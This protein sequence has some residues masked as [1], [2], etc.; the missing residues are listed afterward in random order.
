MIVHCLLL[1]DPRRFPDTLA[2]LALGVVLLVLLAIWGEAISNGIR[3]EGSTVRAAVSGSAALLAVTASLVAA[4]LFGWDVGS[5]AVAW[6]FA[7][8]MVGVASVVGG[9][10]WIVVAMIRGGGAARAGR[11]TWASLSVAVM[12]LLGIVFLA[13]HPPPVPD[14]I[15]DA[16]ALDA[17][18]EDLV[19]SGSPP[20]VSV[21]VLAD[22]ET[23]YENAVG[24]RDGPDDLAATSD[25]V[26]H[27]YSTTKIVTA[28]ATLQLV[29]QDLIDLDDPVDEYVP[30][31]ESKYPSESSAPVTIA[32]LLNHSAGLP[33]NV[34]AVIGWLR[35]EDDPALNQTEFLR[36][37]LPSYDD[38]GF[39]PGTE[40]VYTNVG[41]YILAAVIE[42]VTGED[43][44]DYVVDNVLDPLGMVNTRFEYNDAMVSQEAVGAHPMA[45]FL[46]VFIPLM[47]PPWPTGY[48]RD[49]DAGWI[50][51]ERF[52]FEGNA[53]TGLI[54]PAPEKAR[55]VA[56]V[57]NGGEFDGQRVLSQ[58]SVGTLLIGRH[59]IAGSSPE[60]DEYSGY[61]EAVHGIGW[62][63]VRDGERTFHD[64]SGGGPG[65]AAYMRLYADEGLG[66]V[67]LANGTNLDYLDLADAIADIAW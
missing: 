8:A 20:S 52:L 23:V 60:M 26:Y 66:I 5:I 15:A 25:S 37:R 42:R 31:F 40:G 43:Y 30:F 44:E 57:L 47:E 14:S 29:E 10:V 33:N 1:I 21:V 48:I 11:F 62:F 50:W 35:H 67:I 59:V 34:P 28:I 18:L 51:L 39:E 64:H 54:G 63:V 24:V 53:P 32:D 55:L 49:H 9:L 58:E 7:F 38:L 17:F 16:A 13:P 2:M 61:D 56:M 27:W 41:Y 6:G 4:V 46:T 19:D 12:G 45:D 22:G 65:F 3:S 36:D